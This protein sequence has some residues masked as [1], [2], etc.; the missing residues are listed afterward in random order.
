MNSRWWNYSFRNQYQKISIRYNSFEIA[1]EGKEKRNKEISC[2][3]TLRFANCN[4][5]QAAPHFNKS[6]I[7]PPPPRFILPCQCACF[8][9]VEAEC[10]LAGQICLRREQFW[11]Q[12]HHSWS[13]I[14]RQATLK[15]S[16]TLILLW[17]NWNFLHIIS[18]H[19]F[20]ERVHFC[21]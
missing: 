5:M 16:W 9:A 3:I 19:F 6:R 7:Y 2:K 12:L 4:T 15:Y 1:F 8:E 13:W 21:V 17:Q 10:L 18:K 14:I 20:Y 11:E